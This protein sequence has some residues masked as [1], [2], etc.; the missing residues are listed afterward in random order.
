[1]RTIGILVGVVILLA[2]LK[3]AASIVVPL[4]LAATIAVAFSPIAEKLRERGVPA[5]VASL[6]T[7]VLVLGAIAGVGALVV[8]AVRDLAV[9]APRY[10]E[11]LTAARD[12]ALA[13][14]DVRGLG[15]I[16]SGI[17]TVDA[18]AQSLTMAQ[19][20]V[21][22]ASGILGNLFNV[23]ILTVFIQLETVLL[24][25]KLTRIVERKQS[26]ERTMSAVSEIQRYL[27]IKF[28]LAVANGVLLGGWCALWGVSN[29]ILWG[30][31]AFALNFVPIIGSV[32]AAIPP[33]LFGIL[34]L[35]W[36]GA[37]GIAA[38]Y[39][40]VNIVVDNLLEPRLMG[41]TLG[42]S[43]LVLMM[44]LLLW[45]FVLGPVGALLSV[46][47]TVAVRIYLDNHPETRWIGLLLAASTKGYGDKPKSRG[48]AKAKAE[49]KV[50]AKADAGGA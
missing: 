18:G 25:D 16:G 40:A 15:A 10:A 21:F 5:F 44:S 43:P 2:A 27:R 48:E 37:L 22:M 8:L 20:A 46:P 31:L 42:L 45:G 30:V 28:V 47:I 23:L 4:L 14:L 33:V 17:E 49:D 1:M 41:R 9:S 7:L 3:L 26:V 34:E 35:G 11:D 50:H 12:S 38:G 32:I 24:K 19:R 6:L 36:G 29:P 39:V 13:W